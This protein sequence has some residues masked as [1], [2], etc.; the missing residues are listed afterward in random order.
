MSNFFQI[1]NYA[2]KINEPLLLINGNG[3]N[4]LR[5]NRLKT[6]QMYSAIKSNG[7]KV[8]F[9]ALPFE[10]KDFKA[11]ESILHTLWEMDSWLERFLKQNN[12]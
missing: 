6:K 10:S 8:R 7:V 3:I 5:P 9:V 12:E 1:Q 2:D 11:K 4:N